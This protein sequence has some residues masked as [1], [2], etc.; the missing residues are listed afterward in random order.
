MTIQDG[1]VVTEGEESEHEE[2]KEEIVE[3]GEGSDGS[4]EESIVR[5]V[6]VTRRALSAQVKEDLV[7]EQR[8]TLFHIRCHVNRK[9]ITKQHTPIKRRKLN[10]ANEDDAVTKKPVEVQKKDEGAT[11]KPNEVEKEDF[12]INKEPALNERLFD[13]RVLTL[14]NEEVEWSI[15]IAYSYMAKK[16]LIYYFN[17]AIGV[18]LDKVG[19]AGVDYVIVCKNIREHWMAIAADMRNCKIFVFDSMPNYVKKEL[20]DEALAILA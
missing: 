8:Q 4:F 20:V 10:K 13:G 18:I 2:G 11:P 7:E 14:D 1:E 9:E 17:S 5:D 16:D 19:W 15:T 12:G 6:L 3:V